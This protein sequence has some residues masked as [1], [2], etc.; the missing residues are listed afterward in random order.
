MQ[1]VQSAYCKT[2][3]DFSI[4][5]A[6]HQLRCFLLPELTSK[7]TTQHYTR[8][9]KS[10]SSA[11]HGSHKSTWTTDQFVL[12][13]VNDRLCSFLSPPMLRPCRHR[14]KRWTTQET[15]TW[16]RQH[17]ERLT[18]E[19]ASVYSAAR[20]TGHH[21]DFCQISARG[22]ASF[23]LLTVVLLRRV[24]VAA[25][26]SLV[27]VTT[28]CEPQVVCRQEVRFWKTALACVLCETHG[29][30]QRLVLLFH[31]LGIALKSN[32]CLGPGLSQPWFLEEASQAGSLAPKASSSPK[33]AEL[34]FSVA[35]SCVSVA[36][37]L[38]CVVLVSLQCPFNV[39]LVSLLCVAV[40]CVVL[41]CNALCVVVLCCSAMCCVVLCCVVL[42]C[43]VLHRI[44]L[45]CI[46]CCVRYCVL[47]CVLYYVRY[48]ELY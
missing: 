37:V 46:V 45:Y 25:A 2:T 8:R 28:T 5:P 19:A 3:V 48:Y 18:H 1:L 14:H 23:I 26:G 29:T 42:H 20:S 10:L 47:Y 7:D 9:A 4:I 27:D 35:L 33:N 24:V 38:L 34:F 21:S 11:Q 44:V 40:C 6:R 15:F 12:G 31:Q 13:C 32:R 16:H 17:V 36:L 30:R 43:I 39:A 41:C 22:D